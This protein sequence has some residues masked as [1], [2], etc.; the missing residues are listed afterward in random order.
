VPVVKSGGRKRAP[1]K[2]NARFATNA[3]TGAT[4][5]CCEVR[6]FI[7]WDSAFATWAG[8]PPHAGFPSST[9]ADTW[10]EDRDVNDKR[11]GHR[12]GTHS[13]PIAGCGDEYKSAWRQD[14]ADGRKYC[15]RD[16]PG[17]PEALTGQWQFQLKVI[18]TCKGDAVKATSDVITVAW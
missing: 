2:F 12:S 17:G 4:P 9:P 16:S 18:D 13:D 11:Y 8:G 14:Q 6:Q 3:L 10:I 5:S 7:K 15:G 1:F